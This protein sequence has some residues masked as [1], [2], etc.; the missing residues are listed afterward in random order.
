SLVDGLVALGGELRDPAHFAHAAAGWSRAAGQRVAAAILASGDPR[1]FPWLNPSVEYVLR[2]Q[3]LDADAA[4]TPSADQPASRRS[5]SAGAAGIRGGLRRPRRRA[6]AFLAPPIT[7][8]I[9]YLRRRTIVW[10]TRPASPAVRSS[11][12][13]ARSSKRS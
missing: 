2:P 8:A 6:S 5:A 4:G 9:R 7:A 13:C 3:Q 12:S 10:W 11:P 1:P